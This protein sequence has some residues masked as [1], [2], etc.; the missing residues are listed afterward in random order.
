MTELGRRQLLA[1]AAVLG[2]AGMVGGKS[3]AS[4]SPVF[5]VNQIW[6]ST[7]NAAIGG[8]IKGERCECPPPSV[9]S[10]WFRT[11]SSV[12]TAVGSFRP[13]IEAVLA[14][15]L[16]AQLRAFAAKVPRGCAVTVWHEGEEAGPHGAHVPPATLRNL[17]AHCHSIFQAAGAKYVQIV[18][19]YSQFTRGKNLSSYISPV[20]DAVYLDGYQYHAQETFDDVFAVPAQAITAACGQSMPRGITETNTHNVNGRPAWFSDGY[21]YAQAN[22]HEVYFCF[23]TTGKFL[24][25][26]PGDSAT[27][28][29]LKKI[30]DS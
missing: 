18:G 10:S 11:G 27:I 19:C 16:D 29:A 2:M 20:V 6:W 7:V 25:W 24:S 26:L 28:A 21:A 5:G 15:D 3:T 1:G 23:W 12:T 22:Q 13:N 30:S 14:G 8:G 4:P 17:H 9:P